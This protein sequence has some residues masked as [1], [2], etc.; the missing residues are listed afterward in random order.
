MEEQAKSIIVVDTDQFELSVLA[1]RMRGREWPHPCSDILVRIKHQGETFTLATAQV[2]CNGKT[3]TG[4]GV[5]RKSDTDLP[6]DA[7]GRAIA[8]GR[9]VKS[10]YLKVKENR[11]SHKQF[12]G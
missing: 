1:Q 2:I 12:M 4:E 10:L 8:V 6:S 3:F 7:R 9:A 5:A 11:L